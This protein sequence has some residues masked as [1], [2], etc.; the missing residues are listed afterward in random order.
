W[1]ECQ[2][3][4]QAGTDPDWETI[5]ERFP[6]RAQELRPFL[7][8]LPA[9]S[10]PGWSQAEIATLDEGQCPP[11][12]RTLQSSGETVLPPQFGR[13]LIKKRLGQ[14]GMGAVFLAHDTELHRPV[15]LKVPFAVGERAAEILAR[16]HREARAAATL[17][18]PNLCPVYD[19]GEING[20]HFLT[21]AY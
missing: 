16:F 18:H 11:A 15:A 17:R 21:M 6:G 8:T 2:A 9:E 1:A 20:V 4:R 14:G 10:G 3:R 13:Y 5:R 12:E 19:V 7:D